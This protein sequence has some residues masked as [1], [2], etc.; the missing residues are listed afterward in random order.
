MSQLYTNVVEDV[1]NGVE[2]AI[3]GRVPRAQAIAQVR[4]HYTEV[5]DR[6]QRFLDTPEDQL[7][8]YV[9]RGLIRQHAIKE[10]KP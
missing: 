5:L 4:A 2:F 3:H 6:L 10:L 7:R 9:A 8:V 1:P